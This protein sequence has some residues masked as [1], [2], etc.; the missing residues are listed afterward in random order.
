MI[1]TQFID[2]SIRQSRKS[3]CKDINSATQED[4]MKV[5]GI[6]Q[7]LSERILKM[8]EAVG[9]IVSMDQMHDVWD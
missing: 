3:S 5:Y 9:G 8:K 7:V 6:G 4:L 1:H 2:K